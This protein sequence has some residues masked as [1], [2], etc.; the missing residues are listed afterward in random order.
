MKIASKSS[1]EFAVIAGTAPETP[2]A[3]AKVIGVVIESSRALS[4]A[5]ATV[6][7]S[8]AVMVSA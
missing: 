6:V 2:P 8:K 7:S 1:Y 5:A 4:A 3:S